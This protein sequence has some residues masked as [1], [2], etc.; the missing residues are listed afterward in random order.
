M[1]ISFDRKYEVQGHTFLFTHTY[2]LPLRPI[3]LCLAIFALHGL[4][5]L[6]LA[7]A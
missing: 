7:V 3:G 4:M 5:I 1:R 6:T 2:T